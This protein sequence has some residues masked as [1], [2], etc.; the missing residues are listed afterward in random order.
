MPK[1][2]YSSNASCASCSSS[3]GSTR[4]VTHMRSGSSAN[5]CAT[6]PAQARSTRTSSSTNA[7]MS[8]W[9]SDTARL[10]A[11]FKPTFGSGAYRTLPNSSTTR[12]VR[13]SVGALSTTST[14]HARSDAL[15]ASRHRRRSSGRSL[16]HTAI[17]SEGSL[18]FGEA[19]RASLASAIARASPC[20]ARPPR[21]ARTS[22]SST[23]T[24]PS[25]SSNAAATSCAGTRPAVTG[26]WTVPSGTPSIRATASTSWPGAASMSRIASR[27][28]TVTIDRGRAARGGRSNQDLRFAGC[29]AAVAGAGLPITER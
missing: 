27:S 11:Q 8:P 17:V 3:A 24:S 6:L 18:T 9:A 14:S 23:I 13:S 22:S 5:A 21:T 4:P 25:A 26:R 19:G 29:A 28:S 12:F 7:T 2:P 10:R 1:P 16:V 15:M 20:P